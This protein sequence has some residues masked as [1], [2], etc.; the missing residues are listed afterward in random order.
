MDWDNLVIQAISGMVF[1]AL[2]MVEIQFQIVHKDFT[3]MVLHVLLSQLDQLTNIVD[4]DR[5]GEDH[6]V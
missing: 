2:Q 1:V 5:F 6:L 3:G 4:Q